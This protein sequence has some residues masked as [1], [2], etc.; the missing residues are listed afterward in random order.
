MARDVPER[1]DAPLVE[2]NAVGLLLWNTCNA[3]C[4][5][6]MPES[7]PK[8]RTGLTD[9]QI[10]AAIDAAAEIYGPR[11]CLALS[12]GE[13]FL[14]RDR[15]ERIIAHGA[16]RGAAVTVV[17]NGFW[18]ISDARAL[19]VL[20]PMVEAGLVSVTLSISSYHFE[21]IRP[22]RVENALIAGQKLGISVLIKAVTSKDSSLRKIFGKIR[23]VE[24]WKGDIPIQ[25]IELLPGGRARTRE[26][27][28]IDAHRDLST[29]VCPS[30]VVTVMPDGKGAPCCNGAAETGGLDLGTLAEDGLAGITEKFRTNSVLHTIRTQGPAALLDRLPEAQAEALRAQDWVNVCHL[31]TEVLRRLPKPGAG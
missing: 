13:P 29:S 3:R 24:P 4:A 27:V 11:W 9:E 25:R 10:C 22:A 26:D 2:R 15:L 7:G 8:D 16:S 6:C 17:T 19:E 14:Y 5:H 20:T 30:A 31:C 12:G 1:P 21:Y 18:A 23:R 28:E